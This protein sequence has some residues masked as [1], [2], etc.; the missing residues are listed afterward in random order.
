MGL[1]SKIVIATVLLVIL[2]LPIISGAASIPGSLN[3]ETLERFI[4]HG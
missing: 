1:V 3:P 4:A 2:L